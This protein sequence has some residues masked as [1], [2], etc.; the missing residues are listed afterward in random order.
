M[1]CYS[2]ANR[3][4]FSTRKFQRLALRGLLGLLVWQLATTTEAAPA[5]SA[6]REGSRFSGTAS[7]YGQISQG[8]YR[9]KLASE[10]LR[11][12]G[13][14]VKFDYRLETADAPDSATLAAYDSSDEYSDPS[15]FEPAG[16]CDCVSGCD[17]GTYLEPGCGC[18]NYCEASCGCDE[19][20]C[21]TL[22]SC[23]SGSA[24]WFV[25][26]EWSF[27]KPRFSQNVAFT[28]M[29]GDG[30]TQSSFLDS[31]FDYDLELTP[32]VWIE[33]QIN[34]NWSWRVSYWQFDH[35]PAGTSTSPNANGFGEITHPAFGDVDISTTI[36]TDTFSA[37]SDLNAYTIDLEALKQ[38]R[39]SNWLLGVGGGVRYASTDQSYLA[40][41]RN[42]GNNLR[43]QIDFSHEIEGFGP[44]IS[45]SA[46]RSLMNRVKL[47]CGARGSLLFGDGVSRLESGED[48][49]LANPFTTTRTT[50]RDDL[51]PIG[52]ARIG[53]EW[54][55]PRRRSGGFQW[56][57]SSAMEGQIWGNAGNAASETA[58]MGFFG[59]NVGAGFLR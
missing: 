1:G 17:C 8:P 4:F 56:F 15:G 52:E 54:L 46:R 58:D 6:Q 39:L 26:F 11:K 38:A 50:N 3:L 27:V 51:L 7:Q 49:D 10:G 33:S 57:F 18:D 2:L 59:F 53:L 16:Y 24:A 55:G 23:S 19:G 32:R 22:P 29:E 47:A 34:S 13:R 45:L 5:Q 31:E 35:A 12:A 21:S 30:A 44:T 14:S 43:G 37:T 20:C 41:L 28:T 25:G 40:E 9:R 48:L 42:T 36:P